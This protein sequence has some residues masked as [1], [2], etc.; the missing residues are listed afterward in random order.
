MRNLVWHILV[1]V[2]LATSAWAANMVDAEQVA[3]QHKASF[4]WFPVQKTFILAGESDTLK[5]AIG[6]P[7]VSSHGNP[8]ELKHACNTL[9]LHICF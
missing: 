7:F 1:C 3:K 5:F 4:H 8:I 2:A 9:F 6:L